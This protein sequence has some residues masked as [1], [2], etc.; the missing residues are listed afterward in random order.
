MHYADFLMPPVAVHI[1]DGSAEYEFRRRINGWRKPHTNYNQ[2]KEIRIMGIFVQVSAASIKGFSC[3]ALP[4]LHHPLSPPWI[5]MFQRRW[6]ALAL[7]AWNM[8]NWITRTW[9]WN[10]CRET[11]AQPLGTGAIGMGRMEKAWWIYECDRSLGAMRHCVCWDTE[12]DWFWL[13]FWTR[14]ANST[15]EIMSNIIIIIINFL[16]LTRSR[17]GVSICLHVIG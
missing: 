3:F 12:F 2:L 14:Q 4:H 13:L 17:V 15:R 6:E 10:L 16:K 5:F 1:R 9:R 8:Q 7:F 11:H